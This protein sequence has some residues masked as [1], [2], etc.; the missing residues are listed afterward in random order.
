V[1]AWITWRSIDRGEDRMVINGW[2]EFISKLTNRGTALVAGLILV[3]VLWMSGCGGSSH[4]PI[5]ISVTPGTTSLTVGQSVSFT[6]LVA[7]TSNTAVTWSVQEGG[8]GGT[9]TAAGV[10]TAPMKA[11]TYH[12]MAVSVADASRIASAAITATAPPPG[13]TSTAPTTASEGVV[14]SYS[15]VATDPVKTAVTFTMKSGPASASISGNVLTWTPSHGQSRVANTFD[16]L[17]TT[18]AGGSADQ[19]FTVTPTGIIRGT[20]IDTYLTS[21]GNVTQPEDLSNAYIGISFMNGSSW[22][23]VEGVGRP[24]GTFTVTGVPSGNYWLAIA[25]GGYWT[26]ASDLDLGQDFLG[27]PDAVSASSGTSLGLNFAGLSPFAS[28]DEID[29]TNPNLGQDFD[30]SEN[31]NIGDTTFASV[32]DWAGPLSSAAKG[33]SWFVV[34]THSATA[35]P[36]E[37]RA[38]TMSSSALPLDQADGD[39]TDLS[40]RLSNTPPL[41]VHMAVKGS[42]FATAA[43]LTG[44]GASVHSTI[45]GV[46]S[47]PFSASKG[48]V[49]E[50]EA[51]LETKDQT[52][53]AQDADFGDIAV[54]NPFPASWTPYVSARYEANVPFTATGATTTVEVPAELYLSST[55]MPTKDAPLTPQITPVQ[56]VKLNGVALVQR[57]ATPTL[58][59]TL[60]WDPPATGTPTG[61]R[62]SVYA[63]TLTGATS[64]SQQVLDLFTKDHTMVIPG[65]VL[66]AGNEYFF[67]VRAFLTPSVDFTT[68]PYHSAFPWSHADLLTPVVST[69]GAT[70]SAIKPGPEAVQHILYRPA[71]APRAGNPTRL[72]PRNAIRKTSN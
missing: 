10:Y 1:F 59:P 17:A 2:I 32:W 13:F 71:E 62:V 18:A 14:Y 3:P 6:A 45:V 28:D 51:L 67:Q 57:Q 7:N 22:A 54:G 72:V 53:I 65:G 49:G 58:S 60:S 8:S 23:T 9:I 40:G 21:T 35:G 63:L 27:R 55:Q 29:I 48:S 41:T 68:A 25:S 15:M 66:T 70:A 50:N 34:Q 43:D 16:V 64:T 44:A 52:P 37:W 24:D 5:A 20:A 11:G 33:D 12:V 56:N 38:V 19:T 69:A 26:S 31:I 61:Y 4:Q 30:W 42:Q 46:Y 36:A 39:Q 47:Q